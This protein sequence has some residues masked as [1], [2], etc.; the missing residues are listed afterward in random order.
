MVYYNLVLILLAIHTMTPMIM[1][2]PNMIAAQ[3]NT[4]IIDS[5]T[6][7]KVH[8]EMATSQFPSMYIL[9]ANPMNSS[10]D[11]PLPPFD[12]FEPL[13]KKLY[14]FL[15][16]SGS[17]LH[18]SQPVMAMI[19]AGIPMKMS[20]QSTKFK[21]KETTCPIVQRPRMDGTRPVD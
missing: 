20:S 15:S 13:L 18:H 7:S 1:G 11:T 10:N 17:L 2:I 14:S 4:V 6:Y 9:R 19:A 16:S 21:M 3:I 12:V 8:V 5:T